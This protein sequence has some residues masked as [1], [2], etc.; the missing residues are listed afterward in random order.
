MQPGRALA[1]G[2][3][4]SLPADFVPA[5][6]GHARNDRR[7]TLWI[8]GAASVLALILTA[9]PAESATGPRL[10]LPLPAPESRA[11]LQSRCTGVDA[12]VAP[13]L[14]IDLVADAP[15]PADALGPV[16]RSLDGLP[17][18]TQVLLHLR[19]LAAEPGAAGSD[20][21]TRVGQAIDRVVE[22][23]PLKQ[24]NVRG[25]IIDIA[26]VP[27]SSSLL[28][29]AVAGL[30]LRV[31]TANAALRITVVFPRGQL[32]Q[33]AGFPRR[34]TA[35]ADEVGVL[36]GEGW[37]QEAEW[38]KSELKKPIVLRTIPG[39]ETDASQLARA[40]LDT[41]VET[42]DTLVDTVWAEGAG[43]AE[44]SGLCR[45]A[46]V[47]A[48]A[49]GPGFATTQS[50]H[51][52]VSLS[53][54]SAGVKSM[55]YVDANSPSV[56]F[57][58][59]AGGSTA[60]P[61]S[62][63]V[64][65]KG[66]RFEIDCR[67]A[68]DGRRLSK[69]PGRS[70]GGLP[71]CVADSAYAVV[72]A[73]STDVGN[74]V[75]ES[76]NVTGRGELSVEEIIARW[77]QQRADQLKIQDNVRSKCLMSMHF[78]STA[79]GSGFDVSLQ[80]RQF[81]D[82]DGKR[83]WVQDGFFVNGVRFSGKRGFPLPQ[84]E[85]QKVV[86]QPLELSLNERY[87]YSLRGVDTIDGAPAYVVEV[88]PE[89]SGEMLFSGKIWI[90]GVTFRQ[91]RMD[92]QQGGG[93]SNVLSHA[94]TQRFEVV[95]DEA[96]HSFNLL[97]SIYIQ[98]LVNAAGRSFLLEK[99]L[100]FSDYRINAD[101][102]AAELATAQASD[103]RM[104]RDTDEGLRVL[105]RE[106]Q[107]RV[108][109]PETRRVRSLLVGTLYEGT[110]KYPLP[111]AGLSMVDFNFR[112]SGYQLSVFFAGPILAVNMSKQVSPKFR[113]GF[114]M[115]LSA[116]GRENRLYQGGTEV[117]AE[118]I[119]TYEE[120]VGGLASWQASTDVSVTGSAY[121]SANL[122]RP[123]D[124]TAKTYAAK[125]S[126]L[127]FQS[128]AELRAVR[129]G[130]AFTAIGL[131]GRR[132]RWSPLGYE[133]DPL[134]TEPNF[135]TYSAE[136]GKQF[137]VTAFSKANLTLGY[138]GGDHLDRFSR[139]QPSFLAR[140]RIRGVPSGADSFDALGVA[141]LS[142]GFNVFDVIKLEGLYNR[143]WGRNLTEGRKYRVLDG[144]EVNLGT[145]GPWG[146]FVQG[147]LGY[148]LSGNLDRYPH[149]WSVYLLVFKP[150]GQ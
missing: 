124:T 25:V 145:V 79:L 106:G 56:A 30:V 132:I 81:I 23:L 104:F 20:L 146:T 101:G 120:T 135:L 67:D 113:Y 3:G 39:S 112:N 115:A 99:T 91:V 121:L 47:L 94:E 76:V 43:A 85:P 21:E 80:L 35:Y 133:S 42:G 119:K 71:S 134:K 11:T 93:K 143:A 108:V 109:E 60:A 46:N 10:S 138:Y 149:R 19:V 137:Y 130:F 88:E 50:S 29:F 26:E 66:G 34:V 12:F 141:G 7:A 92:L 86:S 136:F 44:V 59:R 139:Y 74:R 142:Y 103:N 68:I 17:A 13:P 82:R 51:L 55:P 83:D 16:T 41:L 63:D 140:P 97:R 31:K 14:R 96:G 40:Y 58:V 61:Q 126:G 22:A 107:Q 131:Y 53:S 148:A 27:S 8:I 114:D 54:P 49:M 6:A 18:A 111:L 48:D 89:K 45:A 1:R 78:E 70:D 52:S 123:T 72:T 144:L 62:L 77:Q 38:A 37:R 122:F 57:L 147:T 110:S 15:L 117:T 98:E 128:A 116:I 2:A 127:S 5:F 24:Q 9:G 4:R 33:S 118:R 32:G 87:K 64:T 100:A 65:A 73:R 28:Q 129:R 95:K 69:A 90:D 75:Y 102:F 150:L 125:G 36:A 84:L 105:K